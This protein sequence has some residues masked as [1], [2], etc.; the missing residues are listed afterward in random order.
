M[1]K[2]RKYRSQWFLT[3]GLL[4]LLGSLI[5]YDILMERRNTE[6]IEYDRLL[7]QARVIDENLNHQLTATYQSLHS[8]LGG[9]GLWRSGNSYLPEAGL[10]MKALSEANPG[11][12]TLRIVDAHGIVRASDRAE[13]VSRDVGTMA[14][15]QTVRRHRDPGT[16]Y[17][18]APDNTA[19]SIYSMTAALMIPGPAGEF[20][21]IIA[22]TLDPGYFE[23]LLASVQYA[24]DM[25]AAVAHGDGVQFM[26]VPSRE[27]QAGKN[28]AKPGSF[29]SRHL[30]SGKSE[31][32]MT[33]TVYATG[34]ERVMA[35]RTVRP[36]GAHLDKF[37][38]V[39]V[40]RD[41][42]AVFGAWRRNAV[43][44]VSAY[45]L[46]VLI[47][48]FSLSY[49]QQRVHR[50]DKEAKLAKE[51]LEESEKH[52][53][54]LAENTTDV[55]W[56]FDLRTNRY[57]YV[58]PSVFSLRGYTPGEV[59]AQPLE[60]SLTPQSLKQVQGWIAKAVQEFASGRTALM[61]EL[62]EVEQP[63]KDGTTVWTEV[64]ITY[65]LDAE[66]RPVG[67]IGISRDITERRRAEEALRKGEK[68]LFDITSSLAEGLYVLNESGQVTFMNP[69]AERLLGWTEAELKGRNVHDLV[70]H[71]TS[72]GAVLSLEEC[73][74]HQVIMTGERYISRDQVFIRK[75]GTTFPASVYSSPLLENGKV[76]ASVT[77]FRDI[78]ER[79]RIEEEREKLIAE[80][81]KALAEIKTL[82][83]ILPICASC[84]KIRD[85]KGAWHQMEAYIHDH[86]NVEFSHGICKECA[87]KMYPQYYT[88]DEDDADR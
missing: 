68:K 87:K 15:F 50:A 83:G 45:L 60:A 42:H 86:T 10:V 53:R 9:L 72:G 74:M 80:L 16:L 66:S 70:H 25:W 32:I 61:Q 69:E 78:T 47:T 40:G 35:M 49:Y 28:L 43:I 85:D 11:V 44:Y 30:A 38:V 57:T 2:G 58:S 31:T 59:L 76:V 55:V 6:A 1:V 14:Y 46:I 48:I 21:G 19:L 77:A 4:G 81:Q 33:G 41:I 37:L 75:D 67:V 17:L 65:I 71:H 24:P 82:H 54:L 84:K 7:V 51:A 79:K 88:E 39:A 52:Y 27:G 64:S 5:A 22:A 73:P 56:Q 29:F 26:M 12:R 62:R 63:R 23:T 34:E 36:A 3:I 18:S 13:L 20:D 8:I